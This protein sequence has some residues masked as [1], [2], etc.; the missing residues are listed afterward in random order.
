MTPLKITQFL[1]WPSC[2]LYYILVH[3]FS[4]PVFCRPSYVSH[5]L[6]DEVHFLFELLQCYTF[7]N[8]FYSFI[9]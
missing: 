1:K 3:P 8:L 2:I 5:I 4:L 6:F 9:H 7:L